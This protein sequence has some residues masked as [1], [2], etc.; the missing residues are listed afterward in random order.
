VTG[1]PA[2]TRCSVGIDVSKDALD[3]FIDSSA[4]AYRVKNQVGD[5]AALIERLTG[6][7]GFA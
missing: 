4:E 2:A 3:I 5:I 6:T 1:N 7:E